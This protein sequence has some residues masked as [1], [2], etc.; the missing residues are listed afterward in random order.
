VKWLLV[1]D[2]DLP[3]E[4]YGEIL[5]GVPSEQETAGCPAGFRAVYLDAG[6]ER[7]RPLTSGDDRVC[8]LR[9]VWEKPSLSPAELLILGRRISKQQEGERNRDDPRQS[10]G[11]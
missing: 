5:P 11:Q 1:C 3:V 6:I 9:P 2:P 7:V 4:E 10:G 8:R